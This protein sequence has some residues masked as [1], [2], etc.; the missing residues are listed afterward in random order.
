M[1]FFETLEQ[2]TAVARSDL[3]AI[4]VIRDAM[5]GRVTRTQYVA[6]LTEAYH[7]VKHTVPLLMYCGSRLPESAMGLRDAIA[8]YIAEEIG[9]EEWILN[10]IAA[11]GAD[12]DAVRHGAPGIATELMIAYVYDTI[13]RRNPIGFFGMVHVLEG[14]SIAL[15]TN[16]AQSMRAALALPPEAFTYLTSHGAL[17]V[18]HV[19]FFTD[20]MNKLEDADDQAAVIHAAQVVYR[21]YGD[22]FRSLPRFDAAPMSKAA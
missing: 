14:T 6:F 9:H 18:Q 22:V 19:R 2:R 3:F 12:A 10:D 4:P 1:L 21:L 5:A 17:D 8:H 20:L 7:H 16:A 11:A 15:A 13:A